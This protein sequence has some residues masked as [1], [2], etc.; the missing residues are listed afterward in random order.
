MRQRGVI[1]NDVQRKGHDAVNQLLF[2]CRFLNFFFYQNVA[3]AALTLLLYR[4]FIRR[5]TSWFIC[6]F[7]FFFLAIQPLLP[8]T[9]CCRRWATLAPAILT[10]RVLQ[11]KNVVVG[12]FSLLFHSTKRKKKKQDVTRVP[13]SFL[14]FR[15]YTSNHSTASL[16]AARQLDYSSTLNI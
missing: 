8:T 6:I 4:L 1:Y 12:Q 14:C 15:M 9:D 3:D 7:V 13:F 10:A 2:L 16:F 11:S 5:A